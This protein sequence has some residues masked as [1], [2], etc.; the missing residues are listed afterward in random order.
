MT[1]QIHGGALGNADFTTM[2]PWA[3]FWETWCSW[4][5]LRGF[6]ET[7]NGS[8]IMP[9]TR[10]ELQILVDAFTL[11]KAVYELGYELDNRPSWVFIPIHGISQIA[12]IVPP[13]QQ[14]QKPSA[15]Q[16]PP[17]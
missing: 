12:G 2:E 14:Q 5:F 4:A 8:A 17:T 7:A 3:R 11:E 15:A 10:E 9:K 16:T 13:Q 1:N 6:F